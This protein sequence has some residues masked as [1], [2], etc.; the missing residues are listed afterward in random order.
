LLV[1]DLRDFL[2]SFSKGRNQ[3]GCDII[4]CDVD[5]IAKFSSMT[6][7]FKLKLSLPNL[8]RRGTKT[9]LNEP[10]VNVVPLSFVL[11]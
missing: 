8:F 6:Q 9:P 2:E 4:S 5:Y 10:K 3:S 11:K 1:A 7:N